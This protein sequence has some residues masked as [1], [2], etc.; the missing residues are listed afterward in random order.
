MTRKLYYQS[1]EIKGLLNS[2]D[3]NVSDT[4]TMKNEGLRDK[5]RMERRSIS[6]SVVLY[7]GKDTACF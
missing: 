6:H 3:E 7:E 4:G 5:G 1:T 2:G